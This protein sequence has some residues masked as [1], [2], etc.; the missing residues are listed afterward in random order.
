MSLGPDEIDEAASAAESIDGPALV[1]R[2]GGGQGG[3]ELRGDR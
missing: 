1:V 3:G 2:S